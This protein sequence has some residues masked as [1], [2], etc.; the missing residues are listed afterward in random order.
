[1]TLALLSGGIQLAVAVGI[2][3]LLTPRQHILRRDVAGG[4][5]QADVVVML[6]I[7]LYQAPCNFQRQREL[8]RLLEKRMVRMCYSETSNFN[9]AMRRS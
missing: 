5:V 1:V 6:H 8:E 3:L 9:I 4:T 2:D 7:T